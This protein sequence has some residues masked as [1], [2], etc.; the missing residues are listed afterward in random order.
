M[1]GGLTAISGPQRLRVQNTP[2]ETISPEKGKQEESDDLSIEHQGEWINPSSLKTAPGLRHMPISIGFLPAEEPI[3]PSECVV[4]CCRIQ[5]QNCGRSDEPARR[6]DHI[7][8]SLSSQALN[9]QARPDQS[10][11]M[12]ISASR[13]VATSTANTAL[14]RSPGTKRSVP[15][16][17]FDQPMP[18]TDAN[19]ATPQT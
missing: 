15:N 3:A 4:Q 2:V 11:R 14:T 12:V 18:V 6:N 7:H 1:G 10:G 5:D 8:T 9:E 13:R 19:Q 17:A 16:K